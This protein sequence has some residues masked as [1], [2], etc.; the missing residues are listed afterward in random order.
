[1][2]QIEE[3]ADE[4][5]SSRVMEEEVEPDNECPAGLE[6]A[7]VSEPDAADRKVETTSTSQCLLINTDT[8]SF[9]EGHGDQE[10]WERD[11]SLVGQALQVKGDLIASPEQQVD[12]IEEEKKEECP[13]ELD[14]YD[15][16][17]VLQPL[18]AKG[19]KSTIEDFKMTMPRIHEMLEKP[20]AP[21]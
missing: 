8:P 12:T 6:H 20:S 21:V 17:T 14:L 7:V 4:E 1:L 13:Y 15:S 16:Q 9:V 10:K 5:G 2:S 3:V 18:P 19:K 11:S